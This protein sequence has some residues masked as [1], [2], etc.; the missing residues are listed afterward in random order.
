MHPK[1]RLLI[2]ED[3]Q[4]DAELIIR[5]LEK[6]GFTP[7]WERV[8]NESS[9]LDALR[10]KPDLIISDNSMPTFN[11]H[12]ALFLLKESALDIPFIVVSGTMGEEA[13]VNMMKFGADDYLMKS[14]LMR[15]P[16]A[17]QRALHSAEIRSER[18]RAERTLR[19][20]EMRLNLALRSAAVGTW[21]WKR[22]EGAIVWDE[23][24]HTLFGVRPGDY[25]GT[26]RGFIQIVHPDDHDDVTQAIERA[27]KGG[28]DF[29]H[30]FRIVQTDGEERIIDARGEVY[31]SPDGQAVSMAGVCWDVSEKR[32]AQRA[33]ADSEARYRQMVET[34]EEGVW[35]FDAEG[36]TTFVNAKMAQMLG[37]GPEQIYG[38]SLY[39]F[40]PSDDQQAA[41]EILERLR[42]GIRGQQDCRLR[43]PDGGQVWALVST[44]PIIL[45]DGDGDGD[46][47]Y[48]GALAMVT[49]IT[50]R[51]NTELAL[52][53]SKNRLRTLIDAEPE[54]VK[55]VD[56]DG[57]IRLINKAG[58]EMLEADDTDQVVGREILPFVAPEYREAY[59]ELQRRVMSGHS[60]HL[61]F[62][63][64]GLRGARRWMDS[65]AVP[66]HHENDG[67]ITLLSVTRDITA[68]KHSEERIHS[69]AYYDPVTGLPNRALLFDRLQRALID[70]TRRPRMVGVV[71][72]D[73]D[74]FKNVNDSLGHESGD[75]LLQ[76][77]AERLTGLVRQ[78]DTV[79]RLGGDEITIILPDIRTEDDIVAVAEKIRQSLLDPF[80]IGERQ[81]IVTASL[82]V[83][84]Y[85]R[86]GKNVQELLR[87]ADV[88]M[89]RAKELGR[90]MLQKYS[91]DMTM[92]ANQT[93]TMENDLRLVLEREELML[94]YQP[95]VDITSGRMIGMEAL[96]RWN[97][98]KAG[99]VPPGDFI[100]IAEDTGLILPIGEWVLRQACRQ[101]RIWQQRGLPP[102]WVSVNLS[103]QQV[104]DPKL[105]DLIRSV[106]SET[107]MEARYLE[108]ELTESVLMQ[109]IGQVMGNLEQLR[110]LGVRL[111]VDDF[112][113][114]YSSLN[115]LKHFPIHALKIDQS[116][117]S[118]ISDDPSD[119][120]ITRA[121][122]NLAH[123]LN[124]AVVAEGVETAEQ[125]D[126]LIEHQCETVQG[127]LFS[128]PVPADAVPELLWRD[129]AAARS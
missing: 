105:V 24:L 69:L 2:S 22:G 100:P 53:D 18:R 113:I 20:Y 25:D 98:P 51:K 66:L 108:L 17:V 86:D 89:Y 45:P 33:L 115:Y 60:G 71:V 93:L 129:Y 119:L 41:T 30:E 90:N 57:V 124:L 38:R 81:L 26:Y 11:A 37:C 85:P 58:Q 95:V 47:D 35:Q 43:R 126:F 12:R 87:N 13:A 54:C 23:H 74:R 36:R 64:V 5:M 16:P 110:A 107:G 75:M 120:V 106:L 63:I 102:V 44:S 103:A 59:T 128:R 31:F 88:A 70:A 72:L 56:A 125:L 28:G 111:L 123:S 117:V 61:Q 94:H 112:G 39:D 34:A 77:V 32:L 67:K 1:I 84:V 83:A 118:G 79:A 10:S 73:L 101:N 3:N 127:Y 92:R 46:G 52:R 40:M 7:E 116:F 78:V 14:N 9:F 49:D 55:L 19:D 15:L 4:D 42:G 62:E 21:T 8:E 121:I 29:D 65:H 96:L 91:A 99:M 114:G 104:L 68:Q 82:G 109:T 97:H 6:S 27:L 80:A 48:G 76:A 122:I 50:E